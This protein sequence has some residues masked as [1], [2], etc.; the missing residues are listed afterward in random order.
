VNTW[1]LENNI[2]L[3]IKEIRF[4]AVE[5]IQMAQDIVQCRTLTNTR[6][7]LPLPQEIANFLSDSKI[8]KK[9]SA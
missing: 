3:K 1:N 9:E 4:W 7:I 5:W 8:L 2:K 6:M